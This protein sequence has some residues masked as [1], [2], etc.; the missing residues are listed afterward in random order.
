MKKIIKKILICCG[1][2]LCFSITLKVNA[3]SY[4]GYD[5][6]E[7]YSVPKGSEARLLVN[8]P[9]KEKQKAIEGVKWR[10]MGWSVNNITTQELIIY[11]AKTIFARSNKT[12]ELIS[13]KYNVSDKSVVTKATSFTGSITTKASGK[14][15][16]L[17]LGVD[18]QTKYSTE[19]E[20]ENTHQ[21]TTSFVVNIYPNK[22]VS[23]LVKGI[24]EVTNGGSK[25]YFF[26]IPFKKGNYEYI[27][28]LTE[29]YELLEENA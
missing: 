13:F 15:K 1:F 28:V 5:E 27:D 6:F 19:K 20:I 17:T 11:Q 29:Y 16:N 9:Q 12:R 14:I 21:E 2:I 4:T 3:S 8:I 23:L 7:D 25:Y 22:K 10:F 24:A 26:G 18:A